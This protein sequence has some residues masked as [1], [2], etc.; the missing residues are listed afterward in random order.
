ML[1]LSPSLCLS[2][3]VS[4][5]LSVLFSLF[6]C[7]LVNV[8]PCEWR[9]RSSLSE[10]QSTIDSH[11]KTAWDWENKQ[12]Q[13][14][15]NRPCNHPPPLLYS[16]TPPLS[17]SLFGTASLS[18]SPYPCLSLSVC[19]SLCRTLRVC[20]RVCVCPSVGFFI[21]IFPLIHSVKA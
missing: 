14:S 8:I 4:V 13:R 10:R 9:R 17:I 6:V 1:A 7:L 11:R 12:S 18:L 5:S 20:L 19:V 15:H 16:N 2:L 21:T 3:S